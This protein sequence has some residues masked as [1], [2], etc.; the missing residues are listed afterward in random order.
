MENATNAT[1]TTNETLET[2]LSLVSS[3]GNNTIQKEIISFIDNV[4]KN[5]QT[6]NN[7][8]QDV[9]FDY[10]AQK[11]D[12]KKEMIEKGFKEDNIKNK[13]IA[14]YYF[15]VQVNNIALELF[16][17]YN[18]EIKST[19][20]GYKLINT[21]K[22]TTGESVIKGVKEYLKNSFV[23]LDLISTNNLK[24]RIKLLDFA[25]LKALLSN[26]LVEFEG[27]TLKNAVNN[28]S[29]ALNDIEYLKALKNLIKV[30]KI[31]T[32]KDL[33]LD[34]QKLNLVQVEE[35]LKELN[36]KKLELLNIAK[37]E[38]TTVQENAVNTELFEIEE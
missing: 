34:I 18:I 35:L 14:K 2:Q 10:L 16:K 4:A 33:G 8:V 31:E 1:Q 15:Q 26:L 13:E 19:D 25:V 32:K 38:D 11:S 30:H 37:S 5:N 24:L 20:K 28:I 17:A 7:L 21:G 9:Y 12:Y 23:L 6:R 29:P 36:S 22:T 27:V 3:L